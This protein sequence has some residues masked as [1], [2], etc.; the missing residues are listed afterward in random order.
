MRLV[1]LFAL[2]SACGGPSTPAPV[3]AQG[4]IAPRP[5]TAEQ[6][7]DAMPVGTEIRYRI[8]AAGAP[9]TLVVYRVDAADATSVTMTDRVLSADGGTVIAEETNTTAWAKL[10][11]HASFPADATT[12]RDASVEVP[13][14]RYDTTE[15]VVRRDGG[16]T[17]FHFAKTLPGPPV[18]MV[19][20]QG[21]VVTRRMVLESR[22]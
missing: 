8:E 12:V 15:Y 7:R 11:E 3:A 18:S 16:V 14:G 13:A 21:G 20:E 1:L 6:I 4:T 22:K 10:M 9:A 5:Y 2:V 17:T 19:A